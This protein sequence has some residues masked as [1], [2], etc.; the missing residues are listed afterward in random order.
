[1][2]VGPHFSRC[3]LKNWSSLMACKAQKVLI[4]IASAAESA[5][6]GLRRYFGPLGSGSG[7]LPVISGRAIAVA[8]LKLDGATIRPVLV[9]PKGRSGETGELLVD[10][11]SDQLS[12][13]AF[14]G[15]I[16]QL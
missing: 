10:Q 12:N 6:C 15:I 3:I 4:D 2:T 7:F 14:V 1:M 8:S 5:F 16:L 9:F 11:K 13:F